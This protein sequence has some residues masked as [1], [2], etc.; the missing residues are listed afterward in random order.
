MIFYT[1]I[2][3]AEFYD[4]DDEKVRLLWNMNILTLVECHIFLIVI[5][6]CEFCEFLTQ[7]YANIKG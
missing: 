3:D 7:R 2:A 4:F 6:V 5:T 1:F